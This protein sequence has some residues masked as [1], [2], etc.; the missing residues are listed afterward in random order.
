M[1]TLLPVGRA[2]IESRRPLVRGING[3]GTGNYAGT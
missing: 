3:S 2:P 1:P